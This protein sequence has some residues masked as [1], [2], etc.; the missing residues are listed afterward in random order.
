MA[1]LDIIF[2]KNTA[3]FLNKGNSL[4]LDAEVKSP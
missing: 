2:R 1:P 3:I 4:H